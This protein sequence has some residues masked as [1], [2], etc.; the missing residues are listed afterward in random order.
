MASYDVVS[1]ICLALGGGANLNR[2]NFSA[3]GGG[4]R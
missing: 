2:R 1:N 4:G 3:A